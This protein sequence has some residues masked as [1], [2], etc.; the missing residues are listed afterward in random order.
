VFCEPHVFSRLDL[1]YNTGDEFN[2]EFD[3]D[4]VPRFDYNGCRYDD[5]WL[6]S[7]S[8]RKSKGSLDLS[9]LLDR[10]AR[11]ALQGCLQEMRLLSELFRFLLKRAGPERFP[12]RSSYNRARL[13][14]KTR[15]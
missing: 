1:C 9:Q 15:F 14:N 3:W 11:M 5:N 12:L 7:E 4:F 2:R 6:A 10:V 13:E 8:A